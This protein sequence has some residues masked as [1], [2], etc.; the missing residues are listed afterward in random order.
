MEFELFIFYY[1]I[2]NDFSF[3]DVMV[4]FGCEVYFFDL[5]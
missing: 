4:K 1:S 5:R 2:G 3:D